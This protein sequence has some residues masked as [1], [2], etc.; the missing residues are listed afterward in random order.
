MTDAT[1]AAAPATT[2]GGADILGQTPE[3]K[4]AALAAAQTAA[5]AV[6]AKPV[7]RDEALA[8]IAALKADPEW[9]KKFMA[10]HPAA[11]EEMTGLIRASLANNA[12]QEAAEVEKRYGALL[13]QGLPGPD[14]EAGK[15]LLEVMKKGS[16]SLELRRQVELK[17]S[18]LMADKGFVRRWGEGD[19]EAKRQLM[20]VNILMAQQVERRSS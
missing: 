13:A 1:G 11:R 2:S 18:Q 3:E 7:S 15:D 17:R 12:E 9:V 10:G 5:G 19:Q 16:I 6:G 20:V 8:K 4:V 14:T